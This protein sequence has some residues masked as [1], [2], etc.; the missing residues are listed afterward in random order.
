MKRLLITFII[1]LSAFTGFSQGDD[2][3]KYISN[4]S[5]P[6]YLLENWRFKLG[7][8]P[9][10]A[11]PSCNDSSWEVKRP[12]LLLSFNKKHPYSFDSIGWFRLHIHIDSN[13]VDLPLAIRMI[14][15][16]AS[17]IYVDGKLVETFGVINGRGSTEYYNPNKLPLAVDI[18][19]GKHLIAVRYANYDAPAKYDLHHEPMAG[20]TM[21]LGTAN[22][23]IQSDHFSSFFMISI[24]VFLFTF[25]FAFFLLHLV[26]YLYNKKEKADLYF[27]IFCI[28][29]SIIFLAPYLRYSI[30]IP[31]TTLGIY[32]LLMLAAAAS[33]MALSGFLNE[34]FSVKKLRFTIIACLS[35][36]CLV[37]WTFHHTAGA[38]VCFLVVVLVCIEATVLIIRAIIRKTKGAFIIGIGILFF[39]LFLLFCTA[40]AMAGNDVQI[41]DSTATGR[42]IEMALAIVILSIP[43][44]MS[45]YLARNYAEI[46]KDL[47]IQLVNVEA[48]SARTLEQELEKQRLLENRQEELEKEVLNRTAELIAQKQKSDDLLLNILP[49]E[50]AEELKEKGTSAAKYFDHVSVLFTDFVDFTKAGERM[51][52]QQ[53]VDELHTCFKAF[54][55]IIS[56]YSIEKIKTIGDAYLAVSGLP[57]S[58]TQHAVNIT[59]AAIEIRAFIA[60]RKQ[61]LPNQSFNIRIGIHSGSVVAGIVGV[62]KFAYD[63]WGDT[64]NTAARMEQNSESGKINI[65]QS[66]YDLIQNSFK[67]SFRGQITAKNKGELNMYFVEGEF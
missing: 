24:C 7:D 11:S 40:M 33:C 4:D 54:D 46:N 62:K 8:D 63:I 10:Y 45:I 65:S 67:C 1:L 12:D 22:S 31:I 18:P 50:V 34:L 15:F 35:L 59:K 19:P 60:E 37:L 27:S 14:H 38:V 57:L 36:L 29:F 61:R 25:F 47:N 58:D 43:V 21:E 51:T 6:N 20:F 16:G 23:F 30:N 53:L 17:E 2:Y 32:H 64:V 49:E 48:L 41:D 39:T 28:S 42:L 66:T 44:S 5:L 52:P 56:K 9:A 13:V 26:L 3:I 55:D